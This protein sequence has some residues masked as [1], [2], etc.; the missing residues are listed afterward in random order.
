V[1]NANN[2]GYQAPSG[3]VVRGGRFTQQTTTQPFAGVVAI[4]GLA[5]TRV[6]AA[7]GGS[8]VAP[9]VG[10]IALTGQFPNTRPVEAD[11]T[12]IVIEGSGTQHITFGHAFKAGDVPG[13]SVGV[14]TTTSDVIVSNQQCTV[15]ATYSDGSVKHC[16]FSAQLTGG[17]TYK[18]RSGGVVAGTNKTV[19]DLLAAVGGDIA[20][21]ALSGGV[22]G[23]ATLRD[24][25]ESATN[26][27][28]GGLKTVE[29]G[30]Q[31][32]GVVVSRDFSTHVRVTFHCRWYGS[33]LL[34]CD[35]ILENGYGNV[36]SQGDKAYTA[37]C[38][39]NGSTVLNTGSITHYNH[40]MWHRAGWSSGGTL[41]AKHN[42]AYLRDSVKAV[43][44]YDP[45]VAPTGTFLDTLPT[46]LPAPMQRVASYPRGDGLGSTWT[47]PWNETPGDSIEATGYQEAI[48]ILP[49]WDALVVASS[50]DKRAYDSMLAMHDAC[51]CAPVGYMSSADGEHMR[52]SDF[53]NAAISSQTGFASGAFTSS[54]PVGPNRTGWIAS[55]PPSVGFL[56]YL[57]TGRYAYLRAMAAWA[58]EHAIWGST[59]R[60]TDFNGMSI[61]GFPQIQQ[62]GWGWT[63]RMTAQAAW[64]LPDGHASKA[65]FANMVNGNF[66]LDTTDYVSPGTQATNRGGGT[67]G[68]IFQYDWENGF[69]DYSGFMHAFLCQAVSYVALDL[70]FTAGLDFAKFTG[71]FIAGLFGNTGEFPFEFGARYSFKG[72]A[73]AGQYYS[74]WAAFKGNTSNLP[75]AAVTLDSGTTQMASQAQAVGVNS[76]GALNESVSD[77]GSAIY[78]WA[79]FLPAVSYLERLGIHGGWACYYKARLAVVTQ[80]DPTTFAKVPQFGVARR[81]TELPAWVSALPLKQWY[82]IPNTQLSSVSPAEST[83]SFSPVGKVNAWTGFVL[84]TLGSDY[85]APA[86]GGHNDYSGNEV[87]GL[88]LNTTTPA[89]RT[90]VAI[91]PKAQQTDNVARYA[92]GRP[93]SRHGYYN[94]TFIDGLNSVL[95]H[96]CAYPFT[97]NN[98]VGF[99][100]VDRLNMATATWSQVASPAAGIG[101]PK[102]VAKSW[103]TDL[104]YYLTTYYVSGGSALRVYRPAP[105][106]T[107]TINASAFASADS[108]FGAMDPKRGVMLVGP[109]ISTSADKWHSYNISTGAQTDRSATISQSGASAG[110]VYDPDGDRYLYFNGGDI[111]S[112]DPVTFAK[113]NLS[114]TGTAPGITSTG[115]YGKFQYVP[116]LKGVVTV[117]SLTNNVAFARIN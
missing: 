115:V 6:V 39:L 99:D 61:R 34:W 60:N 31:M 88:I 12:T 53:P 71:K 62:R 67:I 29:Q 69:G 50:N 24:L 36:A 43:P 41:Y 113:T 70:G 91:T 112:I 77:Q 4:T 52:V 74:T 55:H 23:T 56:P 107:S 86:Q 33:T 47:Q 21:V 68:F 108:R 44:Y 98:A 51:M 20:S 1:A 3:R 49:R 27:A 35:F 80:R 9:G 105:N 64:A 32:L 72:G 101:F 76:T 30:P 14:L 93:S 37:V 11:V 54:N 40:T 10:A 73:S 114:M 117:D 78:Y 22:T 28:A 2:D 97:V 116:E 84:K 63:Y 18:V 90:V 110:L 58:S 17:T 96:G 95:L 106:T 66:A 45:A 103:S 42:T 65:Y 81:P 48:G 75:A 25:L 102:A 100:A 94:Q 46:T 109:G 82:R 59:S 19:A 85:I 13:G 5:P 83:Y 26:R 92:D 111:I 8:V 7:Q 79:N 15:L 38:T 16:V 104:V 89:W 57:L 87:N